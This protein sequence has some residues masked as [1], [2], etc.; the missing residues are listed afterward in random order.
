MHLLCTTGGLRS[1]RLDHD[2][3]KVDI[4]SA[5]LRDK[6]DSNHEDLTIDVHLV[7]Q[8][9]NGNLLVRV[10]L[11]I[12][13]VDFLCIF[14]FVFLRKESLQKKKINK[15]LNKMTKPYSQMRASPGRTW[16]AASFLLEP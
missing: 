11:N 16:L 14:L 5:N 1:V 8:E 7:H 13:I 9:L 6:N 15:T 12:V 3:R 10:V 2:F 4:H